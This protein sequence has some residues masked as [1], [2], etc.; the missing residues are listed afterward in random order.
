MSTLR[1]A[2]GGGARSSSWLSRP[3]HPK[4]ERDEEGFLRCVGYLISYAGRKIYHSGDTSVDRELISA[5]QAERPIDTAFVSV[6]EK[7]YYRDS[8]GII[9]NMSV[10]DAFQLAQD[11]G[12]ETV[13]PMHWDMFEVNSV[14]LEEIELLHRKLRPGFRLVINPRKI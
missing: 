14:F 5:L 11:V 6:N 2:G 3:A 4:I 9:G 1:P 7:N 12:V 10:R 13:V 8:R